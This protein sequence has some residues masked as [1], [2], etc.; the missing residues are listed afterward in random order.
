MS[1]VEICHYLQ[2]TEI[3]ANFREANFV[4]PLVEGTHILAL[5]LSVGL[6]LMLDLR[7]LRWAFQSQPVSR[8]MRQVMHWALPGFAIMFITGLA[9]FLAQAETVFTNGYFRAKLI[10]LFCLGINAAVF[11]YAFYPK[12]RSWDI[13]DTVPTGAK[14]VALVSLVFWISVIACGRLM[15]YEL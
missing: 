11:Q 5:S 6:V 2:S 13:G 10:L 3:A 4:F 12:M 14:V 15:A 9:L 8:V 1:I 7:L